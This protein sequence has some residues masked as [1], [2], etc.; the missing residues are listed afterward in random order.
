MS[1]ERRSLSEPTCSAQFGLDG[2]K[3]HGMIG[4][5]APMRALFGALPRIASSTSPLLVGGE[6]GTGKNLIARAVHALSDRAGGPCVT[7]DCTAGPGRQVQAALLAALQSTQGGTVILDGIDGL[8]IDLQARLLRALRSEEL[9][10]I[11]SDR[12]RPD[13]RII[14]TFSSDL[15]SAV[16]QGRFREALYYQLNVVSIEAPPLRDRGRDVQLLADYFLHRFTT[17][18]S[19]RRV[20]GFSA[21]ARLAM[22]QW[23]WPGNVRELLNRVKKAIVMCERGPLYS[24]DLDLDNRTQGRVA[25]TL[26][27]A[28]EAAELSALLTA[29]AISNGDLAVAATRLETSRAALCRLMQKHRIDVTSPQLVVDTE[30]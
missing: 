15:E 11:A 16:E 25:M 26:E 4:T 23:G 17:P 18:G 2:V 20:E 1:D 8:S 12:E 29:L 22:Q 6:Q 24:S 27:E 10:G 28:R 7:V 3:N 9:H 14:S 21:E 19:R 30:Q 5:S 13:V